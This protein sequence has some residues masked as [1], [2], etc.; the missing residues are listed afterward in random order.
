MTP[1]IARMTP[2]QLLWA[3][4]L[5]R[6]HQHLLQRVKGFE[7]SANGASKA[8]H[9]RDDRALEAV[10][11]RCKKLEARLAV[12]QDLEEKF[13]A[14]RGSVNHEVVE[15]KGLSAAFD[16]LSRAVDEQAKEL[17][18]LQ[19]MTQDL[20]DRFISLE[21]RLQSID[22]AAEE[23][24]DRVTSIESSI[25]SLE[26][27]KEEYF[28]TNLDTDRNLS[29]M[30]K[31][32][33]TTS[34]CV[35]T[36]TS[37]LK[38]HLGQLYGHCE[39]LDEE[40][41]KRSSSDTVPIIFE[42]QPNL[43]RRWDKECATF[44]SENSQNGLLSARDREEE[45]IQGQ[46]IRPD[47]PE[48]SFKQTPHSQALPHPDE[49]REP[50]R[51]RQSGFRPLPTTQSIVG[52]T[53]QDQ[54]WLRSR[55]EGHSY[56]INNA[57]NPANR[58]STSVLPGETQPQDC[59]GSVQAAP[60]DDVPARRKLAKTLHPPRE[61][62][63]AEMETQTPSPGSDPNAHRSLRARS[64]PCGRRTSGRLSESQRLLEPS[65]HNDHSS[66]SQIASSSRQTRSRARTESQNP[67]ADSSLSTG[68]QSAQEGIDVPRT[69]EK[70]MLGGRRVGDVSMPPPPKRRR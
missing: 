1:P 58:R 52:G 23:A 64:G 28:Q 27:A 67:G 57:R 46:L 59:A 42:T 45:S 24:A 50:F 14:F 21:S 65:F 53:S 56:D 8:A 4:Q 68:L 5:K 37:E 32:L 17:K 62:E 38:W 35:A 31:T 2:D 12:V 6:E 44:T 69:P 43:E 3:Y 10:E 18:S 25:L 15:A 60:A 29:N 61:E 47:Q 70:Q 11:E 7:A 19:L 33:G 30:T 26:Q 41:K 66:A 36:L 54:Q 20:A 39:K 49:P 22:T 16:L 48:S 9:V 51:R 63:N 55:S 40:I 13:E 34:T